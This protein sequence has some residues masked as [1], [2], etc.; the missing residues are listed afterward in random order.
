M[1]DAYFIWYKSNGLGLEPKINGSE[2]KA[3][4]EMVSYFDSVFKKRA[5]HDKLTETV[6][7]LHAKIVK[8]WNFTLHSLEKDVVGVDKFLK[9][10]TKLS[11]INSN[12]TNILYQIKNAT[13]T[14]SSNQ[15]PSGRPSAATYYAAMEEQLAKGNGQSTS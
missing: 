13:T 8:A 2:G 3:L 15:Q 6:E 12:L 14:T 9:G 7:E 11:Q 5:V 4:K 1:M 10:Q